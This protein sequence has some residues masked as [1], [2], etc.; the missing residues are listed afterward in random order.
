MRYQVGYFDFPL[1]FHHEAR[2]TPLNT[3]KT[4]FQPAI[5]RALLE[6]APGRAGSGDGR[7]EK[8]L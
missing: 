8:S 2:N 6:P 3:P 5:E 7:I 4:N 1:G